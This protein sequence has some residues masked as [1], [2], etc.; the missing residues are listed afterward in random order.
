MMGQSARRTFAVVAP[1]AMLTACAVQAEPSAEAFAGLADAYLVRDGAAAA[2]N[3]TENATVIYA[4]DGVQEERIDGREAIE[5]SFRSFFDRVDSSLLLDLNFRVAEQNGDTASG[6]YRLRFGGAETSYGRFDVVHDAG[7]LFVRDR[8]SSANMADFEETAGPLLVRPDDAELDR[9]YYGLLTGRYRLPDDCQVIVTRSV[10]RLFVRNSC[11]QSW[12]GLTRIAGLEWTDGGQVLP[13]SATSSVRFARVDDEPSANLTITA[14]GVSTEAV[15]ATPYSTENVQ[16]VSDDG[17]RLAGTL[18]LPRERRERNAATV[19]VHGSGP[20][21]RDGYASIIAVL[22]DELAAQGRIVLA[23]DKRGSG[24]SQGNGDGATFEVLAA[25][26]S[27]AMAYLAGRDEV[28]ADRIGLAG[29]SQAGWVI[30]K[31]IEAGAVPADVFL[32]GAAGAVFTVREQNLY[33]TDVRMACAGIPESKRR[34]ALEQQSAFFDALGDRSNASRL[35]ALTAAAAGDA[36]IRDWLFPDSEGLDAADAWFT[37]LD[38]SFDPLPVWR[39]YS[40]NAMFLF[41]EFDDSTD[42]SVAIGRLAGLPIE[43]KVLSSAQH[44]GLDASSRCD[45][46]LAERQNFS[47]D[48]FA[49]IA[50]FVDAGDAPQE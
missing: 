42:T 11:D 9:G 10:V 36:E 20:Q 50:D 35:D 7:G 49:A 28:A 46:D 22:A 14:G 8:S 39:S 38:P 16:F 44:L 6:Y 13:V 21:D 27:A 26:A 23:Y 19:L 45:G 17:T 24:K 37:V 12:R 3:Y 48:L 32:L 31:A 30:A 41:S 18:Y 47:A 33:N 34:I 2:R 40:G 5:D 25:D 29:S 1:T 15:Q 4:Y 43:V